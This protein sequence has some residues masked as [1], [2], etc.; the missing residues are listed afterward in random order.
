MSRGG[1]LEGKRLKSRTFSFIEEN[2]YLSSHQKS[3]MIWVQI[4]DI[5]NSRIEHGHEN[6]ILNSKCLEDFQHI[7]R[8]F[9]RGGFAV[10]PDD[11]AVLDEEGL[12]GGD[13]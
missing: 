7:L 13:P 12:A 8:L 10:E 3:S 2:L 4:D 9:F 1:L 6:F 5:L 11:F